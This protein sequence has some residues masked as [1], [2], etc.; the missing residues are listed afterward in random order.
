MQAAT[1]SKVYE[2]QYLLWNDACVIIQK[3]GSQPSPVLSFSAPQ[4]GCLQGMRVSVAALNLYAS[5]IKAMSIAVPEAV[6]AIDAV[7][8][9]VMASLPMLLV[10]VSA[11]SA[12]C[13][14]YTEPQETSHPNGKASNTAG[15][16]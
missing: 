5:M 13:G 15:I 3:A 2:N 12:L 8:M 11:A 10:V 14:D 6:S 7:P 9:D 1:A 4:K 16:Q